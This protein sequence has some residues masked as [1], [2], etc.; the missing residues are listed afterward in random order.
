MNPAEIALDEIAGL[1]DL[2]E[3]IE[4][5]RQ[6]FDHRIESVGKQISEKEALILN[7]LKKGDNM[8]PNDWVSLSKFHD[9]C[10]V[11]KVAE[12]QMPQV[13]SRPA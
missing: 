4:R 5:I 1:R 7:Y 12:L 13:V 11:A 6:E 8:L 2:Q 3:K 10:A 9:A